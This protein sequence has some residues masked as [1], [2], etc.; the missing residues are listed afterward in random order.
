MS[1]H[2]VLC[3]TTMTSYDERRPHNQPQVKAFPI[4]YR[5]TSKPLPSADLTFSKNLATLFSNYVTMLIDTILVVLMTA[6]LAW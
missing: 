3:V 2:W 6:V 1:V 4:T 5:L